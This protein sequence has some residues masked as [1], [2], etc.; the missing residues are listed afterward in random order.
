MLEYIRTEITPKLLVAQL[1]LLQ[2]GYD[3]GVSYAPDAGSGAHRTALRV[4]GETEASLLEFL[5][6]RTTHSV[7]ARWCFARSGESGTMPLD[8]GGADGARL[9]TAFVQGIV[10]GR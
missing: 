7:S 4:P 8:P 1:T 9:I 3:A 6:C 2:S 5:V 10:S